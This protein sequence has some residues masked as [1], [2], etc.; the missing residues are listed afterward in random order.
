MYCL[1]E[2][3]LLHC[4][5]CSIVGEQMTKQDGKCTMWFQ[6]P[7]T[8]CCVRHDADLAAGV[9][10]YKAS[11]ILFRC[12]WRKS[13]LPNACLMWLGVNLWYYSGLRWIVNTIK[14]V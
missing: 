4:R 8:V 10:W 13:C 3:C 14:G 11:V 7:H 2:L 12:V 6:G 9:N 5:L 1:V